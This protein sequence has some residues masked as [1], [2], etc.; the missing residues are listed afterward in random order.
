MLPSRSAEAVEG[1]LQE[2]ISYDSCG[3]DWF[4][5]MRNAL[6]ERLRRRVVRFWSALKAVRGAPRLAVGMTFLPASCFA[7]AARLC[8]Q[9]LHEHQE[10]SKSETWTWAGSA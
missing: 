1:E 10:V 6:A 8:V 2:V 5:T 4:F 3:S 9:D 7:S